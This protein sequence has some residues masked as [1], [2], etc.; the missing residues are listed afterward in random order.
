MQ[1]R[2]IF[3]NNRSLTFEVSN[4]DYAATFQKLRE[5]LICQ[6]SDERFYVFLNEPPFDESHITLVR[7]EVLRVEGL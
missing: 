4:E 2:V 1:F 3:K 5:F 7:G 6:N